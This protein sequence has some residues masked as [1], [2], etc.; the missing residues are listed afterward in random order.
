MIT[1]ASM[2]CTFARSRSTYAVGTPRTNRSLQFRL[3]L[4]F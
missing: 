1:T 4:S 3:D 2:A